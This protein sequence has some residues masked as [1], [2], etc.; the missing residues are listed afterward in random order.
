MSKITERKK[1]DLMKN[2]LIRH[3]KRNI[4]ASSFFWK[5]RHWIDPEWMYSYLKKP[6]PKY[7]L[8]FVLKNKIL[9][10]LD[11]G[12]ATG[13][14]LY[15]L[16]KKNT[17]AI[18]F[19]VDVSLKALEI[20][21]DRFK[22]LRV[23]EVSWVFYQSVCEKSINDFLK[24]NKSTHFD[25]IVFD[26]VLYCLSENEINACLS[27]LAKYARFIFIDDYFLVDGLDTHG[28]KHRDWISKMTMFDFRCEINR[29]SIHTVVE[30][31]NPRS[32][33]F[34]NLKTSNF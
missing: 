4:I 22:E 13:N 1:L 23:S 3:F 10:A 14:F 17:K 19:G 30:G 29:P 5:K 9:S 34:K 12:C 32:L 16:K 6:T 7:L 20:C 21:N 8:E 25:L 27:I 31:A 26:R 33:V 18:C 2:K 28:Y 24:E 11:F 15:D